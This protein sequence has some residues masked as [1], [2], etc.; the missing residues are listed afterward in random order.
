MLIYE[1]RIL[2]V[3]ITIKQTATLN[4]GTKWIYS[5]VEIHEIYQNRIILKIAIIIIII[6]IVQVLNHL[7]SFEN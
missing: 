1:A 6:I 3:E 5:D 7:S 2:A 4:M